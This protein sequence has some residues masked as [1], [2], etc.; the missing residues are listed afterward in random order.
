MQFD[1]LLNSKLSWFP[2]QRVRS[3]GCAEQLESWVWFHRTLCFSIQPGT[4]RAKISSN[5]ITF[6]NLSPF[7]SS[8]VSKSPLLKFHSMT[9][10]TYRLLVAFGGLALTLA[11]PLK[12]KQGFGSLSINLSL[13]WQFFISDEQMAILPVL[14]SLR[15]I[16]CLANITA[17]GFLAPKR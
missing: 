15:R 2:L 11:A 1:D 8:Q 6:L 4:D 17:H 5:R 10:L 13:C 16:N 3:N 9:L 12:S 14:R 7:L